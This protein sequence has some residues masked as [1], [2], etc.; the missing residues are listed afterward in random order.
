[1]L[2][3]FLRALGFT[4][5]VAAIN[6]IPKGAARGAFSKALQEHVRPHAGG[7]RARR[8]A[9]A[10]REP[11]PPLRFQE[12][13]MPGAPEGRPQDLDFLDDASRA[14]HEELKGLLP[15]CGVTFVE[16]P[17]IVRGLD[18]YTLTVFEISSAQL[19]AQN[20]LL[21][22]G[23]YDELVGQLGGPPTPAVGFA[24]GEDRLVEAMGAD[25]RPEQPLFYVVPDSPEDFPYALDVAEQIRASIPD[26]VVETDLHGR[27]IGK[28]LSRAGQIAADL[29]RHAFRV[30][31]VRAVLVGLRERE[32]DSVTIKDLASGAQQTFPRGQMAERLGAA[33]ER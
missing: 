20:A 14:H 10:G 3:R 25:V 12:P 19:G 23:R 28:G 9:P 30:R 13:E 32:S 29:S 21:G 31:S 26:G 6:C 15:L 22:G 24:I 1:M 4:D 16:T 33:R 5:L 18:Y 11:A 2:F 7:A 27:G 8:P 17:A